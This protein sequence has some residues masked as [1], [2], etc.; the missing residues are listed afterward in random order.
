MGGSE[1]SK[2]NWVTD[3]IIFKLECKINLKI[4]K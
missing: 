3:I 4:S 1:K 2:E